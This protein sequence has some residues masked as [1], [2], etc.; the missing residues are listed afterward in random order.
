MGILLFIISYLIEPVL[1]LV[2]TIVVLV[3]DVKDKKWWKH[4]NKILFKIAFDRDRFGNSNYQKSLNLL[5]LKKRLFYFKGD[6]KIYLDRFHPFG[7]ELETISSVLGHN[8]ELKRL[9]WFGW[10]VVLLLFIADVQWVYRKSYWSEGGHCIIAS[11]SF[12]RDN[13]I[14][15][16]RD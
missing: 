2:N 3:Y 14:D 15:K 16:N 6:E 13:N 4:I 1:A 10:V 7:N 5:L 9:N 8:Q 11:K 12:R